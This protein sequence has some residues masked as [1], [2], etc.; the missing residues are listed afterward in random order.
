M[1]QWLTFQVRYITVGIQNRHSNF[2]IYN[3]TEFNWLRVSHVVD[4]LSMFLFLTNAGLTIIFD[5]QKRDESN[6]NISSP[7][8]CN[9]LVMLITDYVPGNLSEVFEEHNREVV[10][11][12]TYIPVRVF[13]YLI[14]KEVTNVA[15]ITSMA[16]NNRG[17]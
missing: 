12:K 2:Y 11:G 8:G 3:I 4:L 17:M 16:C 9:Q 1:C 14:G 7:L 6:C 5:L 10:N 13:T 15:E